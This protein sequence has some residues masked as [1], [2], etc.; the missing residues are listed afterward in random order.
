M[1]N[2]NNSSNPQQPSSAYTSRKQDEYHPLQNQQQYNGGRAGQDEHYELSNAGGQMDS[3][4][5]PKKRNV[6]TEARS[7]I[8]HSAQ[9]VRGGISNVEKGVNQVGD[10]LAKA[11]GIKQGAS[12]FAD[13]RKFMDRG[14]VIDLAVAVIVGAAFTAIVTSLVTDI[15][16]PLIAIAT[17]KNLEENFIVLHRNPLDPPNTPLPTRAFAKEHFAV[18]WN[19]GNFVQ[20]V[21]NFFIISGCVFIL[22]KVYEVS[23][24]SKKEVTEKKCDYC[25]KSIPLNAVR[26]PNCTTWL[27][28]DACAKVANMERVAAASNGGHSPFADQTSH[29]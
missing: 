11:P 2:Y 14:N 23:R 29:F 15:I 4:G 20:T 16:T 27:D 3:A 8:T 21:I 5:R 22:V 28:W 26:C 12:F 10:K 9:A 25:L 17:G 13:Y 6:I 7:G 24:S 18:T 19:W 1:S